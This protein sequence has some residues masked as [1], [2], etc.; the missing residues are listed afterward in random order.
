MQ[1]LVPS[2]GVRPFLAQ[3]QRGPAPEV[4]NTG[5]REVFQRGL[6]HESARPLPAGRDKCDPEPDRLVRSQ[7]LQLLTFHFDL[8]GRSLNGAEDRAGELLPAGSSDP[9]DPYDLARMHGKGDAFDPR[10]AQVAHSQHVPAVNG[11][12]TRLNGMFNRLKRLAEHVVQDARLIKVGDRRGDGLFPVTQHR[13]RSSDFKDFLQPVGYVDHRGSLGCDRTDDREQPLHL[14]G[15]QV[16]RWLIEHK[17]GR[18]PRLTAAQRPRDRDSGAFGRRESFY[19]LIG[20]ERQAH[21]PEVAGYL[22]PDLTLEDRSRAQRVT[23]RKVEVLG[24]GKRVNEA[25]VLVDEPQAQGG[26][27]LRIPWREEDARNMDLPVVGGVVSRQDLD[28]RGL[29]GAVLA[30]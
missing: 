8:S 16:G 29:A 2:G 17:H 13:Y 10:R 28:Q 7:R 14:V 25:E 18:F 19:A 6:L 4:T 11:R 3:P 12:P 20:L 22:L 27:C 23:R 5:K 1:A 26:R 15:G 30:Q 9:G 24:H 21:P